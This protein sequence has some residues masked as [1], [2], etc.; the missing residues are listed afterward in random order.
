MENYLDCKKE[1]NLDKLIIPAQQIKQGKIVVFPT[2]TVYAIG[3]NGLDEEAI[4]KIY[5]VKKRPLDKPIS[6][7]VSD[8]DMDFFHIVSKSFERVLTK[9]SQKYKNNY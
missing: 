2:E 5:K 4:S 3:T 8:I 9:N 7:L 6:L 1:E